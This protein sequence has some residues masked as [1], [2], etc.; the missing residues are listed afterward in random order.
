VTGGRP[1][2]LTTSTAPGFAPLVG[3]GPL[4]HAGSLFQQRLPVAGAG[5]AVPAPY[6]GSMC[7]RFTLRTKRVAEHFG[8]PVAEIPPRYNI[9][10]TQEVL[11]ARAAGAEREVVNLRWGLILRAARSRRSGAAGPPR[12]A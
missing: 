4:D 3:H 7:G 9:A 6:T 11:A 2:A 10:P 8:I 5:I 12:R 1:P